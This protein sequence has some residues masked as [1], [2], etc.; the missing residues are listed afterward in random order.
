MALKVIHFWHTYTCKYTDRCDIF[1][2]RYSHTCRPL[3]PCVPTGPSGPFQMVQYKLIK[4][5]K[6]ILLCSSHIQGAC[7]ML[8][9]LKVLCTRS[10]LIPGVPHSPL[11]PCTQSREDQN[12]DNLTWLCGLIE[13]NYDLVQGFSTCSPL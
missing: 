2:L 9:R 5:L 7:R 10:P 1:C 6:H 4:H 3:D 13:M 11:S 8:W 12:H